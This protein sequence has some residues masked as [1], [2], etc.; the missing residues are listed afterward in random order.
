MTAD[1]LDTGVPYPRIYGFRECDCRLDP[2]KLTLSR[3]YQSKTVQLI[4]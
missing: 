2:N 1:G 4:L 3:Y